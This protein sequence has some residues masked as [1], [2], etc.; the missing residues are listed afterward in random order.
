V[1]TD[2]Q[3]IRFGIFEVDLVVGELRRN[4]TRVKLQEQPFQVLAALLER[5]GEIVSKE[6]LQERIWKEDTF[7]DF[8]RSLATAVNKVRQALGDSATRP[9]FV[10]TVPRRGYRF[11]REIGP[12]SLSATK[13]PRPPVRVRYVLAGATVA[14]ALL[15]VYF[16][17]NP[18][19]GLSS[20]QPNSSLVAVPF[21][22]FRGAE[23]SPSFAP[24]G[25]QIAF[26][27]NGAEAKQFDVYTKLVGS[28]QPLRLTDTLADE[29]S[30]V[31]SPEGRS[32]AFMRS[33]GKGR[34]AILSVPAIGGAER[35]IAEVISPVFERDRWPRLTWSPDGDWILA[36]D[37]PGRGDP[38]EIF[39]ISVE[40]GKKVRLN[41]N[42]RRTGTNQYAAFAPTRDLL[43][44]AQRKS[45]EL[46]Q[47]NFGRSPSPKMARN[48]IGE[49]LATH[50]QHLS[51]LPSGEEIIYSAQGIERNSGRYR[52]FRQRID[53]VGKPEMLSYI[54]EDGVEPTVA[55]IGGRLAYTKG[56]AVRDI[57]L[58]ENDST[59]QD[60]HRMIVSSTSQDRHPEISPNGTKIAFESTRSG[61]LQ[62]WVCNIDGSN[63]VQLT[64]DP[65][66]A[67]G[68]PRWSPDSAQIAF[69][70]NVGE[71]WDLFIMNADGG[72]V[73]AVVEDASHD[74][75]PYWSADGSSLFF[76]SSRS[77]LGDIWKVPVEGGEPTQ[78]TT[79]GMWSLLGVNSESVYYA[80]DSSTGNPQVFKTGVEGGP[81][82]LVIEEVFREHFAL[83]KSGAY[84]VQPPESGEPLRIQYVDFKSGEI[85]VVSDVEVQMNSILTASHDGRYLAYTAK[86]I[87]ESDI[88]LVEGF[89]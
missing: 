58:F 59:G 65:K 26:T 7:V 74:I 24:D 86:V 15:V 30:P 4:G 49:V 50:P 43:A 9:R 42:E 41:S 83:T 81:A 47:W 60:S 29:Y 67:S 78:I 2:R 89:R 76:V 64:Q 82:T 16:I 63:Q 36:L 73:R 80:K 5:P 10:E 75:W 85:R 54:G 38:F 51:F 77:G 12:E 45:V 55:P 1:P 32:I 62:V 8:D 14:L 66:A 19:E 70:R 53:P 33:L 40:S 22:S 6:E 35:Q 79:G 39:A 3:P 27:W 20:S 48:N 57:W 28:S 25:Q 11:L 46:I 61:Q 56:T 68:T 17:R 69:D 72:A 52:L 37:R 84:F 21:T 13:A 87:H 34:G 71:S 23:R 31:W 44:I 18:A 88:M